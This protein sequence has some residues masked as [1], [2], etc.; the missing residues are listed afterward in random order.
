LFDH[1]VKIP[2]VLKKA[3]EGDEAVVDVGNLESL[4]EVVLVAEL[5]DEP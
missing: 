4:G 2:E 3:E 5:L 1:L